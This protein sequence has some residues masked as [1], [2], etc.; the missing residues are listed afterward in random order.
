LEY[1]FVKKQREKPNLFVSVVLILGV[2]SLFIEFSRLKS[3]LTGYLT[4]MIDYII[5]FLF[6]LEVVN[7]IARSPRRLD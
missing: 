6:I 5:L 7:G 1:Q 4:N 3:P 2:A